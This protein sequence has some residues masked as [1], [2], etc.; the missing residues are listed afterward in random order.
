MAHSW[1]EGSAMDSINLN[2]IHSR[3]GNQK[4]RAY[5]TIS[6]A[7]YYIYY[8][9]IKRMR[10]FRPLNF[11][12]YNKKMAKQELSEA[13]DWRDYGRKHGESLFTKVFQN[14]YLIENM[15]LTNVNPPLV[16]LR[17]GK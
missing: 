11:I 8:P 2:A 9:L 1:H 17:R 7:E 12:P 10:T 15:G 5:K 3:F 16:L 4:L 13:L 14:D 6:F